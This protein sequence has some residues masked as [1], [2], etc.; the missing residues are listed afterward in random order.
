MKIYIVCKFNDII[1]IKL[2]IIYFKDVIT[3]VRYKF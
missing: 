2:Q 3:Y 1:C